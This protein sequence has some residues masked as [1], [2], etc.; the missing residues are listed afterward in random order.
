MRE[1]RPREADFNENL[2]SHDFHDFSRSEITFS[3]D[4]SLSATLPRNVKS[5]S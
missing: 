2:E 3:K 4:F 1:G 5:D